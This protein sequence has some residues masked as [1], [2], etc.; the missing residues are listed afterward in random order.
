M[1]RRAHSLVWLV[2]I[3]MCAQAPAVARSAA[4]D[5][6]TGLP[7]GLIGA[8]VPKG[9]ACP[10]GAGLAARSETAIWIG[11]HA[12]E[13][14]GGACWL[15]GDVKAQASEIKVEALCPSG[16]GVK[17]RSFTFDR[18]SGQS[19]RVRP[20]D[21][22]RLTYA[23]CAAE[24][25]A[26]PLQSRAAAR[27]SGTHGF[28]FNIDA[29]MRNLQGKAV[30]G[31]HARKIE[32][33]LHPDG[34]LADRMQIDGSV[35]HKRFEARFGEVVIDSDGDRVTWLVRG[36]RLLRASERRGYYELISWPLLEAGAAV[37]C[38]AE[39]ALLPTRRDGK[40]HSVAADGAVYDVITAEIKVQRC[41]ETPL[42]FEV[43]R[44]PK[45]ASSKNEIELPSD[46][47]ERIKELPAWA[48]AAEEAGGCF[49]TDPEV[50]I[51]ACT[52][53]L[54][55]SAGSASALPLTNRAN[56]YAQKGMPEKAIADYTAALR[57]DPNNASAFRNRGLVYLKHKNY[58]LAL[59]DLDRAIA[60]EGVAL[61]KPYR[62]RARAYVA[63]GRYE[64][65]IEDFDMA[66][67]NDGS[68][69]DLRA[70]RAGAKQAA[71]RKDAEEADAC[72]RYKFAKRSGER[73]ADLGYELR[74]YNDCPYPI[75]AMVSR[76]GKEHEYVLTG[77]QANPSGPRVKSKT[78]WAWPVRLTAGETPS[79]LV[80]KMTFSAVGAETYT[81]ACGEHEIEN[82]KL[83]CF[84]SVH[85]GP[86]D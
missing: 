53:E 56:A 28:A 36:G 35:T 31:S 50:A 10:S 13:R 16:R 4:R 72:L 2:G 55:G 18:M 68:N 86:A 42:S 63:L 19:V 62:Y 81:R 83:R 24:W 41:P 32:L 43:A 44:K 82:E 74:L 9:A 85:D 33:K 58:T 3:A 25:S 54:A 11:P 39:L 75:V 80:S 60:L 34:T 29:R 51:E 59:A 76:R 73:D 47:P 84:D 64:K 40:L 66:L 57:I 22:R 48:R 8:W 49:S 77:I 12:I 30:D 37:P 70:E 5:A 61:R 26:D 21:R 7:P 45:H 69:M 46:R 23:R 14:E 71:R 78:W 15:I 67:R 6:H 20:S 52:A 1:M 38:K 79:Q 17:R 65:A 27:L